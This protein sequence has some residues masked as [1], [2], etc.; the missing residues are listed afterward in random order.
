VSSPSQKRKWLSWPARAEPE[1][2]PAVA[3]AAARKDRD[4]ALDNPVSDPSEDEFN[5]SRFCE[6]LAHT[7]AEFDATQGAPV[8]GL[9]GKWG[10]GKS[11]ALNFI[12]KSLEADER[13]RTAVFS[14]NPWLVQSSVGVLEEF[15]AGLAST[16]GDADFEKAGKD[17]GGLLSA[18]GIAL[19][20]LVPFAGQSLAGVVDHH[21]KKLQDDT[22]DAKRARVIETMCHL[23]KK[24]VVLVD[25]LDRLD[26]D[27]IMTILKT[28]R[29]SANFPNVVYLLAFDEERVARIAGKAYGDDN[30]GDG[31]QFLEKIVQYPFSLPAVSRE[32]MGKYIAGRVRAVC[33]GLNVPPSDDRELAWVCRSFL[34]SRINTPRQA[35]RLANA[36]GFALGMLKG[37]I[38]PFCQVVVEAIRIGFPELYAVMR[39]DS[40]LKS[41]ND[42]EPVLSKMRSEDQA[43]AKMLIGILARRQSPQSI[44]EPRYYMRAFSYAVAPDDIPDTT[45]SEW[46][47]LAGEGEERIAEA[48]GRTADR[49][50]AQ[51]ITERLRERH[52][53]IAYRI[54]DRFA[55]ALAPLG[56]H[57]DGPFN[58]EN[59]GA[60]SL[61]D[62]IA[63]LV[64]LSTLADRHPRGTVTSRTPAAPT[65]MDRAGPLPF[66]RLVHE[67]LL[68][69]AQPGQEEEA[70]GD[71]NHDWADLRTRLCARISAEAREK[72]L[73]QRYG[74]V[75]TGNLLRFWQDYGQEGEQRAWLEERLRQHPS[76]VEQFLGLFRS[77]ML[78][79]NYPLIVALAGENVIVEALRRYKPTTLEGSDL[80]RRILE[81]VAEARKV[82]N[83]EAPV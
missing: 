50:L 12:R 13:N 14:F 26:R 59:R 73:Y 42:L 68:A 62:L 7:I 9:F 37:E 67:A 74:E 65:V 19:A 53:S 51:A 52:R 27:E 35:T 29:L 5:R 71:T 16:L 20:R 82:D 83:G 54:A 55:L 77:P 58:V 25:D 15:F 10:S 43:A 30:D 41:V 78:Q 47:Q 75:D 79:V 17:L 49:G 61:A 66:A 57:F 22:I 72:P 81:A 45:I 11:S 63:R 76:E 18:Y 70:P 4:A 44:A 64:S 32:V 24:V 60:T 46:D 69:L 3:P 39:Q 6:R 56:K 21:A 2:T 34:P 33:E 1:P 80:S 40:S 8:F 38:D 28:V 36:L 23:P 48:I 31:R